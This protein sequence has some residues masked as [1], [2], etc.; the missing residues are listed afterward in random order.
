MKGDQAMSAEDIL[1]EYAAVT[2]WDAA[3]MLVVALDYI[4]VLEAA[5]GLGG[6]NAF[7][8]FVCE[9]AAVEAAVADD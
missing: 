1:R 3:S 6:G 4:E 9:R 7:R 2:G 8:A 5:A